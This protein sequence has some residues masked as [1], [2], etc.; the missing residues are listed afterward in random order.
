MSDGL[1]SCDYDP[2]VIKAALRPRL[3]E[4]LR[5]HYGLD[6]EVLSADTQC[7]QR[8]RISGRK[9]GREDAATTSNKESKVEGATQSTESN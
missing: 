9:R 4:Q 6:V 5:S 7:I 3:L 1:S 8:W 2:R